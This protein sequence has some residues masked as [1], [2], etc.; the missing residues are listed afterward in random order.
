M[1]DGAT[2]FGALWR[3]IVPVMTPGIIATFIFN[4]VNCWNELF[5]AVTLINTDDRKTI[6]TALNGF[7]SSFNIEWGPCRPQRC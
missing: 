1:V 4:F 7:I 6:P 3:V 5:L 2:R